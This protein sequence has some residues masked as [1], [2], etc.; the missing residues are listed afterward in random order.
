MNVYKTKMPDNTGNQ[1]F[2]GVPALPEHLT[3]KH[4]RLNQIGLDFMSSVTK[5]MLRVD[6]I[7]IKRK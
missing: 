5:L 1:D 7:F 6:E 3:F 2:V 4:L